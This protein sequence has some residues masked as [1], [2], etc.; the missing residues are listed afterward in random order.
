MREKMAAVKE[1][2]VKKATVKK[3]R[4]REKVRFQRRQTRQDERQDKTK[5]KT[6]PDKTKDMLGTGYRARPWTG[7]GQAKDR[8]W[9]SEGQARDTLGTGCGQARERLVTARGGRGTGHGQASRLKR[10][11]SLSRL[12]RRG[13][14][15]FCWQSQMAHVETDLGF[16]WDVLEDLDEFKA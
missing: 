10:S 11:A 3:A 14:R 13:A 16:K 2:T 4:Q 12:A 5:D 6:Q 1:T 7:F 15:R 8:P 9:T